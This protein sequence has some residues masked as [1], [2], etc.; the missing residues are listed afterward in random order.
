MTEARNINVTFETAIT[1]KEVVLHSFS[2]AWQ[3]HMSQQ[4]GDGIYFREEA[5]GSLI[6]ITKENTEA[7]CDI[8]SEGKLTLSYTSP[9]EYYIPGEDRYNMSEAVAML[10]NIS[11]ASSFTLNAGEETKDMGFALSSTLRNYNLPEYKIDENGNLVC[12]IHTD[13]IITSDNDLEP[14]EDEFLNEQLSIELEGYDDEEE[15]QE[16]ENTEDLELLERSSITQEEINALL[17]DDDEFP[18]D[19]NNQGELNCT[20]T[21][22][23]TDDADVEESSFSIERHINSNETSVSDI[24]DE[25]LEKWRRQIQQMHEDE[26]NIFNIPEGQTAEDYA[27]R[28]ENVVHLRST[29]DKVIDYTVE[30]NEEGQ[31]V[32]RLTYNKETND[33]AAMSFEDAYA[34]V[35]AAS[36][37]NWGSFRI[38]NASEQE[39]EMLYLAMLKVNA[40]PGNEIT[41]KGGYTPAED[42]MAAKIAGHEHFDAATMTA[43]GVNTLFAMHNEQTIEEISTQEEVTSNEETEEIEET[44]TQKEETPDEEVEEEAITQDKDTQPETDADEDLDSLKEEFNDITMDETSENVTSELDDIVFPSPEELKKHFQEVLKRKKPRKKAKNKTTAKNK[45]TTEKNLVKET[46]EETAVI[47]TKTIKEFL[48]PRNQ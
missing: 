39:K 27:I 6:I 22:E 36:L 24:L 8:S 43:A 12:N 45:Q 37:Q 2:K 46:T 16:T 11:G 38:N 23:L 47:H 42:S 44:S 32:E 4:R 10:A 30:E 48:T 21:E 13:E 33:K 26:Q 28:E 17:A 14:W 18:F 15:A 25:M 29:A 3:E 31:K 5:D 19:E 41:I 35:K 40:E 34:M 1:N 7:I 9:Q 20:E